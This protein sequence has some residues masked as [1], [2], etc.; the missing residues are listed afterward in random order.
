[1]FTCFRCGGKFEDEAEMLSVYA[2]CPWCRFKHWAVML[3]AAFIIAAEVDVI[4]LSYL[5][6]WGRPWVSGG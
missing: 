5:V 4:L 3:P 1:M 6:D 2:C